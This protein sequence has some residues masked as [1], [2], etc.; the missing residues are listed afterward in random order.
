MIYLITIWCVLIVVFCVIGTATLNFLQASEFHLWSDRWIASIWLGMIVLGISLL[1]VSLW[2]PLLTITGLMVAAL[3]CGFALSQQ[4]VRADL[5]RLG[6][7]LY[8]LRLAFLVTAIPIAALMVRSVTWID[9]GLY[10]YSLLQWLRQ[11]GTVPGVAL[12]FANFGFNSIWLALAAPLNP[13]WLATRGSTVLNGMVLWVALIQSLISWKRV[14][15]GQARLSDWFLA[16]ALGLLLLCSLVHP[17]LAEIAVSPSP[18]LPIAFLTGVVSW[19]LLVV[20]EARDQQSDSNSFRNGAWVPLILAVGAITIKLTALPLALVCGLFYGVYHRHSIRQL[21]LGLLISILLLLPFWTAQILTSGCPLFP[22]NLL[23]VN[24]PFALR[25]ED[26]QLIA[27]LTHDWT[28]WYGASLDQ[29]TSLVSGFLTWLNENSTNQLMLVLMLIA[30]ALTLWMIRWIRQASFPGAFWV[31]LVQIVSLAFHSATTLFFRFMFPGL[32]LIPALLI[33]MYGVKVINP[34]LA[35]FQSAIHQ[36]ISRVNQLWKFMA[37]FIITLVLTV[38]LIANPGLIL[39]P[40]PLRS[41]NVIL[42]RVNDFYYFAPQRFEDLCWATQ[43]PCAFEIT[44]DVHLRD[45]KQGVRAGFVR[46]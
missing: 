21:G 26:S 9:T 10:Q 14:G 13:S 31:L 6:Q 16:C 12:L 22:S 15:Q 24:A 1:L 46:R 42:K 5:Q 38:V 30:V 37:L 23:C 40:P 18:D 3:L 2:L 35:N 20:A 45:P 8:R 11:V 17:T 39:L 19:S 43:I 7:L 33:S 29:P 41:V 4:A 34:R 28:A 32:V 44:P 25:Q 36:I 27:K